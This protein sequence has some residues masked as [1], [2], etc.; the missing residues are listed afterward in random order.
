MEVTISE[1]AYLRLLRERMPNASQQHVKTMIC[2]LREKQ[3][4]LTI[5]DI[6]NSTKIHN[7]E[8]KKIMNSL[9][10]KKLV[11]TDGCLFK[12]PESKKIIE[13]MP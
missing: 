10:G 13:I 8:L 9:K 6:E 12:K 4:Y 3:S 2:L 1:L 5:E 7:G 11:E